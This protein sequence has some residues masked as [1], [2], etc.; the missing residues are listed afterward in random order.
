MPITEA[1][2]KY[3][4]SEAQKCFNSMKNEYASSWQASHSDLKTF[5][6][7]LR[8]NF[9]EGKANRGQMINH[10]QL[11][12]G[13]ATRANKTLASGLLSGMTPPTRPWVRWMIDG[14]PALN[15][16]ASVK[17]WMD[18]LHTTSNKVLNLSNC[19]SSFYNGYEEIGQFGNQSFAVLPDSETGIRCRNYTCGE[20]FLRV[21]NRG[22][23][24]AFA[25]YYWMTVG[26][27]VQEFGL[28]SCSASVRASFESNQLDNWVLVYNLIEPNDRRD[29]SVMNNQNMAFRSLYWEANNGADEYL[30]IR[31]FE[32]FPIIA[33]RWET[34]TTDQI[35]G[36][37]PGWYAL[38]AI[39]EL[40]KTRLDKLLM[41]E[42]LQNPPVMEDASVEGHV[43]LLPGGKTKITGNVPNTGV[44]TTYQVPDALSSFLELIREE[45][46]E[47]DAFFFVDIMRMSQTID[48]NVQRTAEEWS[49]RNQEKIMLMGPI[50]Y[51]IKDEL[52]DPFM[53]LLFFNMMDQGMLLPPPKE[54][55]GLPLKVKYVSIL[56]QAQESLGIEQVQ[57]VV[58]YVGS[59]VQIAP[60]TRHVINWK[61][62]VR[63]IADMEGVPEK[64]TNSEEETDLL[65]QQEAQQM[66]MVQAQ[67]MAETAETASKT[68][69]NLADAKTTDPSA[70]TGLMRGMQQR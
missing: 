70:L 16:V 65:I 36:Y 15:R 23:V 51:R 60:E 17:M 32:K 64:L 53:E 28:E 1:V 45:K 19:Y 68:T 52:L 2:K 42:K 49:I 6:N 10:Q 40:Q 41:Q 26:Q 5:I 3:S 27:I 24:N 37:A 47:I 58:G 56:A 55:Q 4:K 31:G 54:I 57:K 34:V 20:Y 11:L 18:H 14:D 25:R 33:T 67:A 7:Q 50:L 59:I 12:S 13:Y 30:A 9:S 61:E 44:R 48:P 46:E 69:K 35:Y 38:G 63:M 22:K 29:V 39:K 62:S 21:D 66:A 8:G 43:N